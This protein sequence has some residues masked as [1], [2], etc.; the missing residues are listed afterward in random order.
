MPVKYR[1]PNP[2]CNKELGKDAK[3]CPRC[4]L[5]SRRRKENIPM[6][7]IILSDHNR[8]IEI[9]NITFCKSGVYGFAAF[10]F[11]IAE[12]VPGMPSGDMRKIHDLFN[13]AGD[14]ESGSGSIYNEEIYGDNSGGSI[15]FH[16]KTNEPPS[17]RNKKI[18]KLIRWLFREATIYREVGTKEY[19]Y[20]K[21]FFYEDGEGEAKALPAASGSEQLRMNEED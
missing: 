21:D 4:G 14:K 12:G 20:N 5:W 7:K 8:I 1:C 2:V 11:R 3:S 13:E 16:F 17:I 18:A 6:K 15:V 9:Y 19:R 10:S